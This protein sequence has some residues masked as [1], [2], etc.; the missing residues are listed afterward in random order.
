M[1]IS[2]RENLHEIMKETRGYRE[3]FEEQG[4]THW[5]SF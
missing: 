1:G 4:T 3:E 5:M 2:D